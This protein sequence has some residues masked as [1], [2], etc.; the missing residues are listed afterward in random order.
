LADRP[1]YIKNFADWATQSAEKIA[2]GESEIPEGLHQG[3]LY[4]AC[5]FIVSEDPLSI[6]RTT[7]EQCALNRWMLFQGLWGQSAKP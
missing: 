5:L 4:C 2:R 1:G 6:E 3:D 7:L